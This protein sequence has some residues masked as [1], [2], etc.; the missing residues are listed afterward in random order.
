MVQASVLEKST[1]TSS[2]FF[3]QPNVEVEWLPIADG[4]PLGITQ[5]FN[6]EVGFGGAYGSWGESY[7]NQTLFTWIEQ[8]LGDQG[9]RDSVMSDI[10]ARRFGPD[11]GRLPIPVSSSAAQP[12]QKSQRVPVIVHDTRILGEAVEVHAQLET[13][14]RQIRADDRV[15][16]P[17]RRADGPK[18]VPVVLCAD[19][20]RDG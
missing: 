9:V 1:D 18:R 8:R 3:E 7:N 12:V 11:H 15:G 17:I 5:V 14:G 13:L 2:S 19:P 4:I 16:Q 10:V 6:P 20:K